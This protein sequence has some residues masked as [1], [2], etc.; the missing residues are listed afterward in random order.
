M[1]ERQVTIGEETFRFG[2][3]LVLATQN[4]LEQEGTY[5]PPEAQT[6]RFL[7]KVLVD[8]PSESEERTILDRRL[9][10]SVRKSSRCDNGTTA[11]RARG[12][13]LSLYR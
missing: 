2:A 3:L 6:D 4:P 13:W 5:P 1:Q 7:M 8:Y 10:R 11:G 9:S 12:R